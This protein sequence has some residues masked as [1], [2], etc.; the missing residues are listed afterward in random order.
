MSTVQRGARYGRERRK[1]CP[2]GPRTHRSNHSSL[3]DGTS[4]GR[5]VTALGSP[6]CINSVSWCLMNISMRIMIAHDAIEQ[7]EIF[8]AAIIWSRILLK[9]LSDLCTQ[10]RLNR[11]VIGEKP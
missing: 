9:K 5:A 7:L 4:S 3:L 11:E 10:L 1:E 8:Q 6:F 2:S